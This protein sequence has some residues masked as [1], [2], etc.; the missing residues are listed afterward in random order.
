[1]QVAEGLV[2]E[3]WPPGPELFVSYVKGLFWFEFISEWNSYIKIWPEL[4]RAA[5]YRKGALLG[6]VVDDNFMC[7]NN[8]LKILRPLYLSLNHTLQRHILHGVSRVESVSGWL[9]GWPRCG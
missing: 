9:G 5:I 6:A 2:L 1:M 7:A 4:V 8:P 3:F